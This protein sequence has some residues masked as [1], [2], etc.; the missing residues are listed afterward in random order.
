MDVH[1]GAERLKGIL[2]MA[3]MA[4]SA[5]RM[6][7]DGVVKMGRSELGRAKSLVVMSAERAIGERD[8]VIAFFRLQNGLRKG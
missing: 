7:E 4:I 1:F 5:A 8:L 6:V 2:L 3:G